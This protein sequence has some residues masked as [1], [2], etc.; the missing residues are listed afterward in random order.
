MRRAAVLVLK[1]A[2]F[3]FA[4]L[5]AAVA[6]EAQR[7]LHGWAAEQGHRICERAAERLRP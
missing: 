7:Q 2:G 6:L 1:G 3:V 5:L 4:P